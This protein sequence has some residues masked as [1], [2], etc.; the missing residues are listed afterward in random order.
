MTAVIMML[1]TGE[2]TVPPPIALLSP[3]VWTLGL[4]VVLY[5]WATHRM[6]TTGPAR[7]RVPVLAMDAFLFG[8]A[9]FF[10]LCLRG[11]LL[12]WYASMFSVD[13]LPALTAAALRL[14]PGGTY[15]LLASVVFLLHLTPF[16][17][18]LR[19][20]LVPPKAGPVLHWVGTVG[21]VALVLLVPLGLVLPF[22]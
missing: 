11:P 15:I 16:P 19:H 21:A 9:L 22:L 1:G 6:Q 5:A 20:S 4:V 2:P 10:D 3:V 8:H 12:E 13:M 18:S 7:T 17:D 14:V